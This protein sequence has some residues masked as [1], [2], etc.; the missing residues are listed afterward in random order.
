MHIEELIKAQKLLQR[1]SL[2]ALMY[3]LYARLLHR[4]TLRTIMKRRIFSG[5]NV[6]K[7]VRLHGDALVVFAVL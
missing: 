2:V 6:F 5:V 1:G 7:I 4:R 3:V